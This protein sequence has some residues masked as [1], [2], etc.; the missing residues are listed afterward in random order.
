MVMTGKRIA[1]GRPHNQVPVRVD[2]PARPDDPLPPAG[3]AGT[4]MRAGDMMVAGQ[5]V[6]DQDRGARGIAISLVR[7]LKLRQ[8][9]AAIERERA[10]ELDVPV[11]AETR[12]AH[13]AAVASISTR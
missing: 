4:G 7:H 13:R 10:G 8:G 9:R 2:R 11:E 5:G 6:A 1:Y 3:L 12:I